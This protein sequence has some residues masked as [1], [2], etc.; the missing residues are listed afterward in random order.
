LRVTKHGPDIPT[1]FGALEA[2]TDAAR[3]VPTDGQPFCG[4]T[5]GPGAYVLDTARV[6]PRSVPIYVRDGAAIVQVG[7]VHPGTD[8]DVVDGARGEGVLVAAGTTRAPRDPTGATLTPF[9]RLVDIA[10]CPTRG[11]LER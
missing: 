4:A 11:Q 10:R 6:C 2:W 9:V 5:G 3:L 8:I 7:V 1:R